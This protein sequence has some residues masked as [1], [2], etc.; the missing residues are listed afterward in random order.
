MLTELAYPAA[1]LNGIMAAYLDSETVVGEHVPS[2]KA[3]LFPY[4]GTIDLGIVACIV[5]SS[6][7]YVGL[8]CYEGGVL[9]NAHANYADSSDTAKGILGWLGVVHAGVFYNIHNNLNPIELSNDET[10]LDLSSVHISD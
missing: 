6:Y 5:P 8:V 1:C 9:F 4:V 2:H 3:W 10:T 7:F